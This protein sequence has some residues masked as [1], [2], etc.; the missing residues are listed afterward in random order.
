MNQIIS[1]TKPVINERFKCLNYFYNSIKFN[2][3]DQYIKVEP[4][5]SKMKSSILK[6][7]IYE[8]LEIVL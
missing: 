3:E 4:V 5:I 1:D 6:E 8:Y 2:K 7:I